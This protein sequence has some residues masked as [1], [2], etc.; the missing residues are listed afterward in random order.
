MERVFHA[1]LTCFELGYQFEYRFTVQQVSLAIANKV[2]ADDYLASLDEADPRRTEALLSQAASNDAAQSAAYGV[3]IPT[4]HVILNEM[5]DR[6]YP[7]SKAT[8]R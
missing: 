4:M 5:L 8:S 2:A 6:K 7:L 1:K 3:A